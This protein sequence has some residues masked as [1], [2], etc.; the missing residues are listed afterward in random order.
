MSKPS[1]RKKFFVYALIAC[2]AVFPVTGGYLLGGG[3]IGGWVA[4]LQELFQG[5]GEGRFLLFPSH[6]LIVQYSGEGLAMNSNFW[7]LVPALLAGWT[8]NGAYGWQFYMVAVQ[9]GT[10]LTSFLLFDRFFEGADTVLP[11]FFGVLFYMT[12]PYRIYVCYDLANMSQ[13][14]VWMLL[15]L[16]LWGVVG[17]VR[18]KKIWK[19]GLAAA[20]ALAGIGYADGM[21]FVVVSVAGLFLL[22]CL[23]RPQVLAATA[24]GWV[25]SFPVLG[26]LA[27]YLFTGAYDVL[28]IP[29]GTIMGKGYVPGE[30]FGIFV[31]PEGHPGTGAGLLIGLLSGIWL[32]FVKGQWE[33]KGECRFFTVLAGVFLL[34]SLKIFPWEFVQRLG[35]WALKFVSLMETP[36]IFFGM[37]QLCLCI[38][39]AWAMGRISGQEDEGAAAGIPLFTILASFAICIYQCN[40]LMYTRMPL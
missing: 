29:L 9:L 4:R 2:V 11:R 16:Y 12:C 32:M 40:M 1:T 19:S 27:R 36:A 14:M 26:R 7:F 13:A 22:L 30:F 21:L 24:L 34:L 28:E 39:G 17:L 8:G 15:P 37:A 10:L 31:Y 5:L 18:K 35:G 6:A 33:K 3:L 20:L 38:P 25:L 23:R